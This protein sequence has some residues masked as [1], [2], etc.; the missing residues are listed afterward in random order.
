MANHRRHVFV[1]L[2]LLGTLCFCCVCFAEFCVQVRRAI[3]YF[4]P[5]IDKAGLSVANK[6]LVDTGKKELCEALK[7]ITNAAARGDTVLFHCT[8]GKDRTGM[9]AALILSVVR[10]F[11]VAC[12]C[13]H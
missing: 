3:G 8:L 10:V 1:L 11:F 9:V 12:V 2:L 6:M 13:V 7:A 4:A 5:I